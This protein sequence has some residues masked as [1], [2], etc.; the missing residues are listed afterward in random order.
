LDPTSFEILENL[1]LTPGT[2]PFC[3]KEPK[4][5]GYYPP[6]WC[7][8]FSRDISVLLESPSEKLSIK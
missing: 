2:L 3:T 6:G 5:V 1:L 7:F 4:L 8:F